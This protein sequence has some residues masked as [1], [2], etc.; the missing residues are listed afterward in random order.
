ML[1]RCN[2]V[3][4]QCALKAFVTVYNICLLTDIV[5][6]RDI[7]LNYIKYNAILQHASMHEMDLFQ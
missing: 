7:L 6:Y 5:K 1:T 4:D 2:S 3:N